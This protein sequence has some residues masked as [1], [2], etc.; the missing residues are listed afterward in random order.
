MPLCGDVADVLQMSQ[1]VLGIP[2]SPGQNTETRDASGKEWKASGVGCSGGS[3]DWTQGFMVEQTEQIVLSQMT[4]INWWV[5]WCL[6]YSLVLCSYE[7]QSPLSQ[8]IKTGRSEKLQTYMFTHHVN[9]L[10]K[11][12]AKPSEVIFLNFYASSVRSWSPGK[13]TK[14]G[15]RLNAPKSCFKLEPTVQIHLSVSMTL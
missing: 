14:R 5:F 9:R 7:S 10:L 4:I 12:E 3:C 8:A 2:F 1:D 6:W 11:A 15:G 13:W